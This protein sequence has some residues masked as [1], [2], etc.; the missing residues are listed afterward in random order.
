MTTTLRLFVLA[1][2]V[3]GVALF[4]GGCGGG[5]DYY[6]S[7][8]PQSKYLT[9]I[10]R[11]QNPAGDPVGGAT[12]IVDGENDP[13]LTDPQFHPLGSGYPDE[14]QGW[15]ANWV[16]DQYSVV[17]NFEGDSDQFEI[18][19]HKDG[20]L[21]DYTT[22]LVDDSEPSDIFIRDTLT[23]RHVAPA[24]AVA[25]HFAEVV[26][27]PAGMQIKSHRQPIKIIRS[28]DDGASK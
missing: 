21:D 2:A 27:A 11:V 17:M 16:S 23:L 14:W 4:A 15:L 28:S 12:I 26:P 8:Y 25:P 10:M 18:R 1:L 22:V 5:T 19:A 20:W 3:T 9:L 6:H 13:Q 24:A 7:D